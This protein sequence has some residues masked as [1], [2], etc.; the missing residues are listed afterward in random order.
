MLSVL[1]RPLALALRRCRVTGV[2]QTF[3]ALRASGLTEGQIRGAVRAGQL[4][5][6]ATGVYVPAA[7]WPRW[8]EERYRLRVLAHAQRTPFPASHVSA[9]SIH[10]LPVPGADLSHVHFVR[11]GAGGNR[12]KAGRVLH[13]G[14][15]PGDMITEADGVPVTTVARSIADLARTEP[16]P[17]ALPAADAALNRRLCTPDDLVAALG[18]ICSH[19][20]AERARATLAL[21]DGRCESPGETWLRLVLTDGGLPPCALQIEVHD[22]LGRFVGRGDAGYPAEGVLLEYDGQGKYGDLLEPGRTAVDALMAEKHR[23][24]GL[25]EL[26]WLVLRFDSSHR[27]DPASV[28]AVVRRALSVSRRPGWLPPR[29]SYAVRPAITLPR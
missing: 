1:V 16:R 12:T 27:G 8:P 26:G 2:I 9:V 14:R 11:P 3:S 13:T 10:G 18:T 15:V 24:Q 4:V 29:G 21:A 28:Q 25:A 19:P 5:R 20:G 6:L 17:V 22:E 7:E 23:H